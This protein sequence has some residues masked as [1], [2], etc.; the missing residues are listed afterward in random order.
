VL[1]PAEFRKSLLSLTVDENRIGSRIR[2][3]VLMRNHVRQCI[4]TSERPLSRVM[5]G[6]IGGFLF[7]MVS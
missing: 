6:I 5:Q 1:G 2:A 7:G 4:A 3:H